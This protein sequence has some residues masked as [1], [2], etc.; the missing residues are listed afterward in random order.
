MI[1]ETA[2]EWRKADFRRLVFFGMSGVGKTHVSTI[3]RDSGAWFHYSVDYRI[4]TRYMGEHI[5][6]NFKFEAMR[7]PFLADL[8]RSDSIYIASNITFGNL[9]PLSTYMG[10]P[11]KGGL[12]FA[13]YC[14]RQQLHRQA[15]IA[16]LLDTR[17]FIGRAEQLYGYRHFVCDSGGSICEVVDPEN[18][19]DKILKAL[20][21]TL[22][23][24]W[25]RE[26]EGHSERLQKRFNEQPKPM[27]Y[28]PDFLK[29]NWDKYL[30]D[31]DI[32][33]EE[34]DPADFARRVY[35]RA[36]AARQPRYAAMA[37][38]WGVEVDAADIAEV[39]S[40]DDVIEIIAT[41]IERRQKSS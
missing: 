33:P 35:Q 22:L 1:Y 25:I 4:G 18:H 28:R 31:H 16:A 23:L 19:D 36:I 27:Y 38:N 37:R 29:D 3:L 7:N 34:V 24:V 26:P 41:S 13:E 10:N 15:E 8:L 6:D 40:A 20:G 12:S 11:G 14:R 39:Q 21:E 5:V 2:A 30:K 9:E 32:R 17:H